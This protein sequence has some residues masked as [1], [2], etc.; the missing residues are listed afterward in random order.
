MKFTFRQLGSALMITTALAF[1]SCQKSPIGGAEEAAVAYEE[2]SAEEGGFTYKYVT[3]DQLKTRIYTLENGLKIYLTVNKEKPRIQTYIAV[4][5]GSKN[6]PST[7]TGLAHYLEHMVFKGTSKL[8]TAD[9]AKE[10]PM[11]DSIEALFNTYRGTKDPAKRKLI[12]QQIDKVSGEAAKFAIANEYDKLMTHIGA[13]G[14]NAYTWVDQTVY[15][16]DIPSNNLNK[17]AQIEAERFGELVP[18]LFH[19]E[20]EAVYEEK[21]RGLDSDQNKMFEKLMEALFPNHTYGT[22]TTIGTIEHLKNPSITE[23]KKFFDTYYVP[24][25]MAVC[26]SG[27][28]DPTETV[29]ILNQT[30][31]KLK[32]KPLPTYGQGAQPALTVKEFNVYGPEQE[33][34]FLGWRIPGY[35]TKEALLVS[36]MNGM[37]SNGQAGVMDLNLNNKQLV[38]SAS[39]GGEVFKEYGIEY[40][41][42]VP[43]QGQSLEQVRDL[44]L[45]QL[46]SIKA[47]RFS[48]QLLTSVISNK[49]LERMQQLENNDA[50]ASVLVNSFVNGGNYIDEVKAIDEMSKITADDMIKF[51]NSTFGQN[52]IVV[53]KRAGEDKNIQKVEKP[54]ITPVPVNRDQS[55]AFV[56]SI[57]KQVAKPLTPVFV[58]VN[59]EIQH[60][61]LQEGLKV[62]AVKNDI[63]KLFSLE[64]TWKMGEEANNQYPLALDYLQYLGTDTKSN[65]ALKQELYMLGI[66]ASFYAT[67]RNTVLQ[68][69]GLDENLEKGLA[70]VEDWVQNAKADDQ[71]LDNLKS[72][73]I[74]G[75][76][77]AKLDK[78]V[79]LRQALM[80]YA[81]Y[82][83]VNNLTR[84]LKP[85][86]L[87]PI[88]S[89]QLLGL[90]KGLKGLQHMVNYYGPRSLDQITEVIKTA[91]KVGPTLAPIPANVESPEQPLDQNQVLFVHYDMVQADMMFCAKDV[92]FDAALVPIASLYNSYFDGSMGSIVFQELRESKALAYSTFSNYSLANK[93]G[94]S[95]YS[96]SGIGTQADKLADAM[97]GMTQL[98]NNMPQNPQ[99]LELAKRTMKESIESDRMSRKDYFGQQAYLEDLG[100]SKNTD[101]ETYKAV[102][103][104][105]MEQL[106]A[107]QKAHVAGKPRTV[108][109]VGNRSKIDT[110]TLAQY[111]KVTELTLEQVFGY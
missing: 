88:T 53:Y 19:T 32:S 96:F 80:N 22:Q 71:V 99:N 105:T 78:G 74:K 84:K 69:S 82:G 42:G 47:G 59:K 70:L 61:D 109:L 107:F 89:A 8:G 60:K 75:K 1:G 7:A 58:D 4:A 31:G 106:V 67:P 101:E 91:H 43:R 9:W 24:N 16:N 20:L 76:N 73:L 57:T 95:N 83:A 63:N 46:D 26:M 108:I 15:V 34:L 6:D 97:A 79:I 41:I 100:L 29:K 40:M 17:W 13:Q 72:D 25:N 39:T 51:A 64:L 5:A 94:K 66:S 87:T 35:G 3:G 23:I 77:D 21:N 36:L 38:L 56:T 90:S 111:G 104:I 50:R 52:Y 65:A 85:A 33:M 68:L 55:S 18:R 45:S 10:K 48:K 81:R 28:L 62:Q 102:P 11:L 27:D 93:K 98:L 44:L 54:K 37:L 49:K 30:L 110:K 12:Y 103:T 14:T 92:T 86:E 2:K